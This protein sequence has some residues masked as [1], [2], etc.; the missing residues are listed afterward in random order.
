MEALRGLEKEALGF[1]GRGQ[2]GVN[3]PFNL[4]VVINGWFLNLVLAKPVQLGDL[5][6]SFVIFIS[7]LSILMENC[8][9]FWL[10]N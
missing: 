4:C 5:L 9:N 6:N 1:E 2:R 7:M 10:K 8:H 3:K